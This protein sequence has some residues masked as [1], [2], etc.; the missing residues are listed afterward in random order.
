[1]IR[2]TGNRVLIKPDK[3]EEKSTA[4]GIIL[5]ERAQK[6]ALTGTIVSIGTGL[7]LDNGNILTV[8]EQLGEELKCGDRVMY[9]KISAMKVQEDKEE[10]ILIDADDLFGT[11]DEDTDILQVM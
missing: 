3:V 8:Q 5:S 4:N 11:L 1:M 9:N 7:V 2:P 10:L 6:K